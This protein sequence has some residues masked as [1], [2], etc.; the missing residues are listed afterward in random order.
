MQQGEQVLYLVGYT[1]GQVNPKLGDYVFNCQAIYRLDDQGSELCQPA[2]FSGKVLETLGSIR[3]GIGP[4]KIDHAGTCGKMGQGVPSS[5]GGHLF[6][7]IDAHPAIHIG[8][9]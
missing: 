1:G 7:V 2:I 4:L 3:A 5:G 9:R 6:T 8:G